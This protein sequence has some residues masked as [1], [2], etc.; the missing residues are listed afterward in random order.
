MIVDSY[1]PLWRSV[2]LRHGASVATLM[3]RMEYGGQK[4][5]RAERRFRAMRPRIT[6]TYGIVTALR[7]S[8][9]Q[10]ETAP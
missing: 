6:Y 2:P 7:W 4:G 3:R 5:R 8:G 10:T 1:S 9:V